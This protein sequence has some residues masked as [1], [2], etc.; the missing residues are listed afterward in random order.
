MST[1][2]VCSVCLRAS[3]WHG[4]DLCVDAR[5]ASTVEKSVDDLQAMNHEHPSNWDIDPDYGVARHHLSTFRV[6]R[7]HQI[8][9]N[10]DGRL[11]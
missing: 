6:Q 4:Y 11:R 10:Q 2:T 3:C 7:H 8:P 1:I 5:T 9:H